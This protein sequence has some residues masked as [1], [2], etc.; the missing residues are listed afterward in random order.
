MSTKKPGKS[1][2][3]PS[4]RKSKLA[5]NKQTLRDLTPKRPDAVRGGKPSGLACH[6]TAC[7][8]HLPGV[9]IEL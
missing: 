1:A 5:L 2:A 7:G 6:S 8:A 4:T 9:V 3:K